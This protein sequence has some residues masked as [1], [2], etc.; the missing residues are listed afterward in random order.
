MPVLR[1]ESQEPKAAVTPCG[2]SAC[3]DTTRL[4]LLRPWCS[5][6][7]P[8]LLGPR[9]GTEAGAVPC[10]RV[11]AMVRQCLWLPQLA[12]VGGCA[13]WACSAL[14]LPRPRG[15]SSANVIR[16]IY[17][18]EATDEVMKQPHRMQ[19]H[20]GAFWLE[21]SLQ[22][23]KIIWAELPTTIRKCPCFQT[24]SVLSRGT[25]AGPRAICRRRAEHSGS[26]VPSAGSLSSPRACLFALT[27]LKR[28]TSSEP[29]FFFPTVV[30]FY[31][32]CSFLIEAAAEST[33]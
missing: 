12:E 31:R 6:C 33:N 11:L 19:R 14:L 10:Q 20:K 1:H 28:S 13:P 22:S 27:P 18:K 32:L 21:T 2:C 9:A 7:A 4:P 5:P 26:S 15:S 3:P 30:R 8:L 16:P 24:A 29:C 17:N 25:E 23:P